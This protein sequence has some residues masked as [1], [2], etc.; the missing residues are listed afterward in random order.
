MVLLSLT[1]SQ[2]EI[3]SINWA[4]GYALVELKQFNAALEIWQDIYSRT[5][6]HKALHQVGFV[7]RSSGNLSEALN[8][9]S[10]EKSLISSS[11][12]QAIGVNLYELTYCHFLVKNFSQAF[13]L[14]NEYENLIF[15]EVDPVERGCFFRLKGDLYKSRDNIVAREAYLESIVFFEMANDD[16]SISEIQARLS[17]L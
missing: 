16:I 12:L 5:Q 10:I 14:F 17:E 1:T 13:A 9:F 11:D 2:D 15:K 3:D 4:R 7:Q 6:D 8:V